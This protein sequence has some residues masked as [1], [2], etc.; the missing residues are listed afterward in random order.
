MSKYVFLIATPAFADHP[1]LGHPTSLDGPAFRYGSRWANQVAGNRNGPEGA[2]VEVR[3]LE[4]GPAPV[5]HEGIL[6]R[7]VEAVQG[8]ARA[9]G[10]G[11]V[12]GLLLG[13]GGALGHA[14]A[15]PTAP[16]NQCPPYWSTATRRGMGNARFAVQLA[17]AGHLNVT[18]VHLEVI[19]EMRRMACTP[20]LELRVIEQM[21][22]AFRTHGTR[23]VD[24][25]A[26]NLGAM[27]GGTL[28]DDLHNLWGTP[29]RGARGTVALRLLETRQ[30]DRSRQHCELRVEVV[31]GRS[32][33]WY[34]NRIPA[35]EFWYLSTGVYEQ[36]VQR[37]GWNRSHQCGDY[38]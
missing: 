24:L 35:E 31:S 29:V 14:C 25:Y 13:H 11:G 21:G 17:P 28:L 7:A 6:V 18:Q 38:Q 19:R 9:A 3:A 23:R 15:R 26:C 30:G 27:A 4:V 32:S 22:E 8:A 12:V 34:T 10:P 2:Q 20:P 16:L 1:H 36:R 37:P 33:P 5:T